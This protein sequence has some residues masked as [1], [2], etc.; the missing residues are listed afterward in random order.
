MI[1][2]YNA[3]SENTQAIAKFAHEI[4]EIELNLL[5]YHKLGQG[6]YASLDMKYPLDG[7]ETLQSEQAESLAEGMRSYGV[8]VKIVL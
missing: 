8:P 4:G 6:K 3:T 5:P 1:P 2:E 7:V